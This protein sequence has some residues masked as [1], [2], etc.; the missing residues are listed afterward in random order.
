MR[1]M[2]SVERYRRGEIREA[3][4]DLSDPF[5]RAIW[6][7]L[8]LYVDHLEMEAARHGKNLYEMSGAEVVKLRFRQ[9]W[10][11][12][13]SL[14]DLWKVARG[15]GRMDPGELYETAQSVAEALF[16]PKDAGFYRI[17]PEFWELGGRDLGEGAE[18]G[19]APLVF[20][21]TDL[22]PLSHMLRVGLGELVSQAEAARRLG[23]AERTVGYRIER[24]EM[25]AVRVGRSVLVPVES[26]PDAG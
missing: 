18:E 17:P 25:R 21:E 9:P 6:R 23:V 3:P 14:R 16:A 22:A 12:E 24:G 19:R 10:E 8:S 15:T 11:L 5:G 13:E 2:S 4:Y 26:L 1:I 7:A 20:E